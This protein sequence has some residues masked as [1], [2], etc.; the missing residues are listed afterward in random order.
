MLDATLFSSAF[1]TLFVI[2][3]PIGTVPLFLSILAMIRSRSVCCGQ[4]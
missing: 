1:V 4:T 2:M 3:D